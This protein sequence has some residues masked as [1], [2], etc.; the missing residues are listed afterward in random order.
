MPREE[1]LDLFLL[2]TPRIHVLSR[3]H[4]IDRQ[5]WLAFVFEGG[6]D[7]SLKEPIKR[8]QIRR[9]SRR[10]R[11]VGANQL[12]QTP[13]RR[14]RLLVP[15][16]FVNALKNFA[17]FQQLT[18]SRSSAGPVPSPAVLARICQELVAGLLPLAPLFFSQAIY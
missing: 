4:R 2:H 13:I 14:K 11:N 9:R 5:E 10:G 6:R 7:W 17:D 1:G 16:I 18:R 8:I 12:V 3:H 15:L